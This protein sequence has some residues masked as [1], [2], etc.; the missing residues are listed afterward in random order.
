MT[1]RLVTESN[2]P[3][4]G[5]QVYNV[6]VAGVGSRVAP[7]VGSDHLT[8]GVAVTVAAGRRPYLWRAR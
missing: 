2:K 8:T 1:T 6:G 4:D 3:A 5:G 7:P